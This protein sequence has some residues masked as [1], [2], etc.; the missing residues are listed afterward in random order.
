MKQ[1][2]S[3]IRRLGVDTATQSVTTSA[4]SSGTDL[5]QEY[6]SLAL[7]GDLRGARAMFDEAPSDSRSDEEHA[8]EER[9]ASRFE[10]RD[11]VFALPVESPLVAEVVRIYRDYWTRALTGELDTA[12]GEAFLKGELRGALAARDRSAAQAIDDDVL[13]RVKEEI[14]REGLRMLGGITR[15]FFDLMLWSS[16]ESRIFECRLTDAT[17]CVEVV[18][19]GDF[20]VRG[21]SHFATFGRAY[22]GGWATKEKLFC[23]RDDYDLESE[24]FKVSYL[25]HEG[26]HFADYAIYPELEQIDLEYRGKLTEL[27]FAETSLA[28]MIRHFAVSGALNPASPHAYA[29]YC[30]VRDLSKELFGKMVMNAD[31]PLW[32]QSETVRVHAAARA[33]LERHSAGLDAAGAATTHGIVRR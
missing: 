19:L 28:C 20:L 25:Q 6:V 33:V 13:E 32:N 21:W 10:R 9:F 12:V 30:V 26:R 16:Q 24:Q 3:P 27:A 17:R 8:L 5:V 23:L 18:F 7:Q 31:H 4:L 11:E 15:P 14:E 22:T 29:N 1:Y 2:S